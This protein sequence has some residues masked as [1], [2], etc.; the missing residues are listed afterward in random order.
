[1]FLNK[2]LSAY[3]NKNRYTFKIKL[4]FPY[5]LPFGKPIRRVVRMTTYMYECIY[6]VYRVSGNNRQIFHG[7]IERIKLNRKV[8]YHFV[9][10]PKVNEIL[11]LKDSQILLRS[12]IYTSTD[13]LAVGSGD[14]LASASFELCR[15]AVV[16]AA[17]SACQSILNSQGPSDR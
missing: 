16:C 5:N 10:L 1:M 15:L 3:I 6:T 12:I 8:L 7:Q 13:R 17:R 4:F 9:S 2:C 11:I 14:N